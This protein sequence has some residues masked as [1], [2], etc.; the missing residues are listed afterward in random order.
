MNGMFDLCGR[1]V[2]VVG[3]GGVL[4]SAFCR[5]VADAGASVAVL[6]RT[7]ESLEAVASELRARG[8]HAGGFSVDAT[9]RAQVQA[10]CTAVLAEF[11]AVDVLVNAAGVHSATPFFDI[12]ESEWERMIGVNLTSAFHTCQ[13]FGK[14]MVEAGRGGSIINIS[15]MASGPPLSRVFAY[16][17][18]KAGLN[19]LTQYRRLGAYPAL[20]GHPRTGH[21]DV[22]P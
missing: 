4:G 21:E 8:V 18:A 3:G 12:S 7:A 15:S 6:D 13:T 1:T 17:I 9:D 19:N 20:R 2:V 5:G 11:G 16:G 10:C 22:G 14:I